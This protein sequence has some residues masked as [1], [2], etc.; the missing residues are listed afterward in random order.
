MPT[1]C[2]HYRSLCLYRLRCRYSSSCT[3][4]ICFGT[5]QSLCRQFCYLGTNIGTAADDAGNLV[6]PKSRARSNRAWCS[7]T[8]TAAQQKASSALLL[9]HSTLV[10]PLNCAHTVELCKVLQLKTLAAENAALRAKL[11]EQEQAAQLEMQ[12][13][14]KYCIASQEKYNDKDSQVYNDIQQQQQDIVKHISDIEALASQAD[15]STQRISTRLDRV[16]PCLKNVVPPAKSV[17]I[18]SCKSICIS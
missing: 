11:T 3:Y 12:D 15:A 14:C 6:L 10:C 1:L 4:P 17:A 13:L 8:G 9:C 7:G 16:C 5:L 2:G 18:S